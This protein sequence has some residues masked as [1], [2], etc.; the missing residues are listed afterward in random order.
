MQVVLVNLGQPS[1]LRH[2]MESYNWSNPS[3]EKVIIGDESS[4]KTAQRCGWQHLHYQNFDSEL[5]RAFEGSYKPITGKKHGTYRGNLNWLYV[6]FLRFYLLHAHMER[7][8]L[9][10]VWH[11]DTDAM[12]LKPLDLF[13]DEVRRRG[14]DWT[15]VGPGTAPN[16]IISFNHLTHYC[17]SMVEMFRDK[18]FI[19]NQQRDFKIN[20]TYA[21]T[22]MRGFH[23]Y[24]ENSKVRIEE[25]TRLWPDKSLRCDPI[26]SRA[27]GFQSLSRPHSNLKQMVTCENSIFVIEKNKPVELAM[28]NCSGA[29]IDVFNWVSLAIRGKYV[30]SLGVYLSLAKWKRAL[31]ASRVRFTVPERPCVTAV[32][33]R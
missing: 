26:I 31:A 18:V 2:V 15:I 28:I 20:P 16:G 8:S 17:G 3:I 19:R 23:R 27:E 21:L 10:A 7:L 11:A 33:P 5:L 12:I 4:Y 14:I 24:A 30:H 13:S 25:L 32:G 6:V 22:E 29:P 1:F 9:D